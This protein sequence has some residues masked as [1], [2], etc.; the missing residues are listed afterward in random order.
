MRARHPGSGVR[1]TIITLAVV[2]GAVAIGVPM[3]WK[4][5]G[6]PFSTSTIDRTPPPVLNE[7]RDL[8]DFHAAS[9]E[10]EVLVDVEKDVKYLPAALAGEHVFF[11]GIGSVDAIVDFSALGADAIEMDA[12]RMAVQVTLPAPVLQ[13]AIVDPD[14]S[15]VA[16]RDRG[17]FDRIGGLFS[18]NPTSETPLYQLAAQKIDDSAA[19]SELSD[20]AEQ[21][22]ERML[23]SLLGGLGFD[24][25]TVRFANEPASTIGAMASSL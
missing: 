4:W 16:D 7:L 23:R 11:I 20:R 10:F 14:R 9:G 12:E 22:T 13:A 8:A 6:S 18:D 21:N 19:S 17:L 15:H 3:A 24:E 5:I 1:S 2:I 25:V